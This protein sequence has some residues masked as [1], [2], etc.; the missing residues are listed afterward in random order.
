MNT[1]ATNKENKLNCWGNNAE[2]RLIFLQIGEKTLQV[3]LQDM[4][5]HALQIKKIN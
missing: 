3:S 1:C 4:P 2:N 5:T